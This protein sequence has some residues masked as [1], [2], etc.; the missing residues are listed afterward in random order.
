ME[1]TAVGRKAAKPGFTGRGAHIN[2]PNRFL[3]T[4]L[5]PDLEHLEHD[6]DALAELGRAETQYLADQS[7]SIVAENDSP[8][9]PFRYSI[10]P[11]RGCQHGCSYCYARPTHEYLGFS[12]GLDFETRILVKHDAARL[13]RQ[14]LS[15][16]SWQA[17]TI[18]LSGV[19]DGYQP[20]ERQFRLTR[21]CLEVALEARQPIGIVTKNALVTRDLD[22]LGEMASLEIVHVVLSITTLDGELA[23]AME[24]R[25][26]TPQARLR[27]I[28][29]LSEAGVPTGVMV[30]PVIP[31]LTDHEIP[32]ILAAAAEA[33]ARAACHTHLRL[34]ATVQ[35]VFLEWLERTRPWS[36]ERI[37]SL[38]RSMRDGKLNSPEFGHRMHGT[39]EM[40]EQITA[41][42]QV[43]ARKHG[44]DGDLP[45]NRRDRFRPPK[46]PGGQM[47]LF[48]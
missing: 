14:F 4:R 20:A 17:E 36:R 44:L 3:P 16:P 6:E 8:D 25:T 32:A 5:E 46:L 29:D 24:P 42:F 22:L 34:P 35:P 19:T 11:Y 26:S 43:F 31:G 28:R 13:L 18:V 7:Q 48:E 10:N 23:R 27:A 45:P 12:A 37:E 15:R 30:A 38:I 9:V 39:G 47:R 33:G 40:A 41:L 2:P 1:A 21:Q